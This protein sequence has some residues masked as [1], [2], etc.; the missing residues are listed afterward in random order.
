PTPTPPGTGGINHVIIVWLENHESTS[1]TATSMPYYYG[2]LH[3]YGQSTSY[4]AVTH[5]SLPNYLAFRSGST[6]GVPD[7]T[8]NNH[9]PHTLALPHVLAD[10][11]LPSRPPTLC[12]H[13]LGGSLATADPFLTAFLPSVFNA[14][15]WAHTALFVTFDEGSTSSNGGGHVTM[16][17]ARPGLS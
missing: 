10:R 4:Y 17:V 15:D 5:P 6:Q 1:V 11:N 3:T 9:R 2:L 13:A 8:T 14:T 16:L 7:D 12:T